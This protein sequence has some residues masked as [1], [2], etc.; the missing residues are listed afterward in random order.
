M[1]S[2]HYYKYIKYKKKY[3]EL[4]QGGDM[5]DLFNK[6]REWLDTYQQN[7]KIDKES[8]DSWDRIDKSIIQQEEDEKQLYGKNLLNIIN[9]EI[10]KLEDLYNKYKKD[11]V[12]TIPDIINIKNTILDLLNQI[13]VNN[14]NGLDNIIE[15]MTNIFDDKIHVNNFNYFTEIKFYNNL[16]KLKN[17][18]N[19]LNKYKF[20]LLTKIFN[21]FYNFFN[22]QF[23]PLNYIIINNMKKKILLISKY[24]YLK[25][26]DQKK[27]EKIYDKHLLEII[28]KKTKE[29]KNILYVDGEEE[30]YMTISKINDIHVIIL[31]LLK[32][33]KEKNIATGLEADAIETKFTL[34]EEKIKELSSD[35]ENIGWY[36]DK[37]ILLKFMTFII[38]IFKKLES[39]STFP[40]LNKI[41]YYYYKLLGK[42]FYNPESLY[43]TPQDKPMFQYN[44]G[45]SDFSLNRD[46]YRRPSD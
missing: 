20:P 2:V 7:K 42:E 35:V 36:N 26:E 32:Q 6:P 41:F 27:E 12:I 9:I 44:F 45:V 4:K 23:V 25:T 15:Q 33:I 16:N 38:D 17:D 22:I 24:D 34:I 21:C 10:K 1:E 11:N 8:K 18:V 3:L 13:Q 14:I 37:N 30:S 5:R 40:L 43:R 39:I 29:L 31:D 28:K 46:Y 19:T